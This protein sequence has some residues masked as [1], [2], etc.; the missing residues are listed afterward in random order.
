[1][2]NHKRHPK[3]P[4]QLRKQRRKRRNVERDERD[5]RVSRLHGER[6]HDM[7]GRKMRY[8]SKAEAEL[9]A[10]RTQLYG[11]YPKLYTYNCPYCGGWHLTKSRH[12]R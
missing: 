10:V 6:G 9:Y 8:G 2:R 7:C 12:S 4:G 5:K 3:S 1:M 11:A